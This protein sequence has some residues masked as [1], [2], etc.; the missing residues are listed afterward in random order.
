MSQANKKGILEFL[1]Y[2]CNIACL[3]PYKTQHILA[4][5]DVVHRDI[6]PENERDGP[7]DKRYVVVWIT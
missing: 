5:L 2:F 3:G 1:Q 6:I 7:D 4:F